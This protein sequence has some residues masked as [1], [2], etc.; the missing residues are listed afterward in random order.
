MG[1]NKFKSHSTNISSFDSVC[2]LRSLYDLGCGFCILKGT[3]GC[4][5]MHGKG[6][7]VPNAYLGP[8]SGVSEGSRLDG[9]T[10]HLPP[11]QFRDS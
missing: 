6:K 4:P 8:R 2:E 5:K 7:P 9:Y 10:L 11:K 3:V 1:K